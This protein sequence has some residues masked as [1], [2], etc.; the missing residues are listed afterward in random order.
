MVAS[1]SGSTPGDGRGQ[2]RRAY[3]RLPYN[4]RV[5]VGWVFRGAL[6]ELP[7]EVV[8]EDISRTGIRL[9]GAT[10][11]RTGR[12]GLI[13]IVRDDG[14]PAVVGVE[15]VHAREVGGGESIAG[16]RFFAPGDGLVRSVLSDPSGRVRSLEEIA[17]AA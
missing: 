14:A 11:F 5:H 7:V 8:G 3:R 9:R 6:S 2:E 15:V 13:Q 4:R 1:A 17:S 16:A 10:G 12:L